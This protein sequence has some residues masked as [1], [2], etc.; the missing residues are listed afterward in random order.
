MRLAPALGGLV[1]ALVLAAASAAWAL[2]IRP[3]LI[4]T[5]LE[6]FTVA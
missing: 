1:V 4:R 2:D 6:T 3:E 5:G